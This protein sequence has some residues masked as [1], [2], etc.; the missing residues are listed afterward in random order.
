MIAPLNLNVGQIFLPYLFP[1]HFWDAMTKFS[2]THCHCSAQLCVLGLR[3][4]EFCSFWYFVGIVMAPTTTQL[5]TPLI[6][7][8]PALP[9]FCN[10]S[11]LKFKFCQNTFNSEYTHRKS[12]YS[13]EKNALEINLDWVVKS[14]LGDKEM[15]AD[16]S[17]EIVTS[18]TN[19]TQWPE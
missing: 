8:F 1:I 17:R 15:V 16:D 7:N 4:L 10:W 2:H 19:A 3:G 14:D 12:N 9:L 18:F 13:H 6:V 11:W 5:L